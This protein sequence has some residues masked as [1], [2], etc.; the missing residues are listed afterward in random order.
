MED[1]FTIFG[2]LSYF[3]AFLLLFLVNVPPFLMPPSWLVLTSFYMLDNSLN[4]LFLAIVGAT[5]ATAGRFFLLHSSMF[6]QRFMN[7]ERKSSLDKIANYLKTK[8]F[9]YL[10]VTFL[11]A[12]SPLPSNMLF[13]GYGLMR[14]RSIQIYVG[15]WFGRMFAYFIM[16]SIS[17]IVLTP[18]TKL[19][20]DRLFGIIVADVLSVAVLAFF[21]SINWNV[22]LKE[23]KIRFVK[24]RLWR[25]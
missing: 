24:P 5:G 2:G 6:F 19:F 7:Q 21:T 20:E 25:I 15:F 1:I 9:G 12:S 16:I 8:R 18:F 3:G 11:F 10:I 17:N 14:A 4:P 22:L 13:I 23:K